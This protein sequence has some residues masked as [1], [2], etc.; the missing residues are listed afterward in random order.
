[1]YHRGQLT[2]YERLLNIEP[3][4]TQR[5]RKLFANAE[6]KKASENAS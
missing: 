2:V 1:M 3:A 6:S 4:L 5:F